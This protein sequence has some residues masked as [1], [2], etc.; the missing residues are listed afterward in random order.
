MLIA[1]P[2]IPLTTIKRHAAGSVLLAGF[3]ASLFLSAFLLFSVQ[4]VV[5]R[6]LLPRLGGSPAVWNTCVCF[7]QVA[8]LFGYGYAH[9][10]ARRLQ[11]RAQLVLHAL[12]LSSGLVVLPLSLGADAPT[13]AAAPI[14]WLLAR[15]ALAVGAPFVAIAA[16]APLLQ[17]WFSLTTHPQARDP[18]FLYVASNS[19]SLLALLSYP[20][21]IETTLDLSG[22]GRLWSAGFA[23]TA[24]AVVACGIAAQRYPAPATAPGLVV[25]TAALTSKAERLRWVLLAF[26]PS[27]LMLAVTTYITTDIAATPLF[28][29]MPLAIYIGTFMLAF[30]RRQFIGQRTLLALQGMALAA[31]GLIGMYGTPTIVSLISSLSAFTLTA[32]VCHTELAQRRPDAQGLTGYYILISL[33]GALGGV[34]C[35]LLAPVLFLGPWEYPLLLIAACLLRPPPRATRRSENW[36]IRGDLLLPVALTVLAIALLWAASPASPEALRPVAHAASIVVPGAGLLWFAK[37]RVRLAMALAGFLLFPALVDV[38]DTLMMTRSFFGVHR[39]RRLPNDDLV[40][41]Q[42]GTTIHGMQSTRPGEEL[43]PLGYYD[44]AGPFGRLFAA[45]GRRASPISAVSVLG[46]GTGGLG[47]YARP[48]EVWTFR[49]IDPVVERLARDDR[50]FHFM[51][52]CGNHSSVVLGDARLT[53]G[54]DTAARYDLMVIDV[55]SSDSVPVH[56]ITR[57]ALA[58]YFARLKPGGVVLF[59]VSNRYL[60][61][62]PVVARLAADAGAPVRHL[63][64]P[65][66]GTERRRIGAEVVAV[67]APGGELDAL[68]ADGWDAPQPGPVLWTDESSNILGVIRWR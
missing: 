14:G 36:A 23:V 41:L 58:L 10:V 9:F 21:L 66:I 26:V 1:T 11:P 5:S 55:F 32:A 37:R 56:L 67:A 22:Q 18:Y 61:L 59:H 17:H 46:L 47:C 43:T 3:T 65:S 30:A 35:A 6:M 7:F 16:T 50:W 54:A 40:V 2:D 27:A 42:H 49:E 19:G 29:V 28:W 31:A 4:P 25:E 51:A 68:A 44:A 53:L 24:A 62:T 64:V 20:V 34:F 45:L 48:G 52:G 60:D 57:E 13:A 12:V 39:V 38:S 8:L 63:L 15:L 33:G